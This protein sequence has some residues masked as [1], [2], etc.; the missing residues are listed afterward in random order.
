MPAGGYRCLAKPID[1]KEL[2]AALLDY[3]RTD[4]D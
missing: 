3:W 1:M 4:I 2:L